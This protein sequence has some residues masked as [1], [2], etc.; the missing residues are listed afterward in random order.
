MFREYD[1]V[2]I[3]KPEFRMNFSKGS[4]IPGND[5]PVS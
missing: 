2:I 3:L 4:L 1:V 5:F